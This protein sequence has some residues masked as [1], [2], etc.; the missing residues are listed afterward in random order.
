MVLQGSVLR[1]IEGDELITGVMVPW[2]Y[3]GSHMSAFCWHVEDHALYSVNY[4]HLGAPKVSHN[5]SVLCASSVS[6]TVWVS[7][8]SFARLS[9]VLCFLG[10][11]V[12]GHVCK[13]CLWV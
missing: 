7:C 3:V 9:F 12:Y 13:A 4:M 6:L 10:Y 5:T 11:P 8:N 1:Y 2:L